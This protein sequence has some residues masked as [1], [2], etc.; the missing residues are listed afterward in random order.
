[1]GKSTKSGQRRSGRLSQ[2]LPIQVSGID[3]TGR[4][5]TTPAHTLVLSRYGAEILLKTELVPDQEISIGLLGNAKDWDARVVG[6]FSKRPEGFAYGIEFLFQDG[7]FWGISFPAMLGS[8]ETPADKKSPTGAGAAKT[9]QLSDDDFDCD[10]LLKKVRN[11][12][13]PKTFAVRL[14][15]PHHSGLRGELGGDDDQWLILQ[16]RH[17]SL[18]QVFET[19]WDFTCPIHGAQREYPLEAKQTEA[20]FQIRFAD[21]VCKA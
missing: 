5:F 2:E 14:K 9:D 4:D 13:P 6:L 19:P 17:E 12:P 15:C 8:T 10:A 7:N 3:A 18:Q 21:P 16:E 20:G 11:A 1:M